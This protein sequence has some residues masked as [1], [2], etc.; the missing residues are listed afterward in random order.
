MAR[1]NVKR[2]QG[3]EHSENMPPR[4]AAK[5]PA[6]AVMHESRTLTIRIARPWRDVYDFLAE[7]R[8]LGLWAS[9]L[10]RTPL[11]HGH[12]GLWIAET[13]DGRMKVAFPGRN[14]FGVAD[15]S[16]ITPSG[17]TIEVPIRVIAN[18][19]GAE[20]LFTLFCLPGMTPEKFAA[21]AEWVKRDLATLKQL[22]EDQTLP[23]DEK[24]PGEPTA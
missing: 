20:V 8:N 24:P 19:E 5:E 2:L 14:A 13:P 6:I 15:H 12:G 3:S 10:S 4:T 22:L 7:P 23:E 9:G 18:G 21:D 16:V 17:E 11:V 1:P